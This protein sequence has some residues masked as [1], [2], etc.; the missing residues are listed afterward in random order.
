[1]FGFDVDLGYDGAVD[2]FPDAAAKLVSGVDGLDRHDDLRWVN[3]PAI[4][5]SG[6]GLDK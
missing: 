4:V 6:D 3:D 5:G 2:N 1:M